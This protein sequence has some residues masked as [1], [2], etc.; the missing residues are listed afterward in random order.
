H[1]SFQGKGG[2]RLSLFGYDPEKDYLAL[3][4]DTLARRINPVDPDRSLLLLK[5]T[6]QIQHE[7]GVRFAKG[8]WPYQLLRQWVA[9]GAP[10]ENGSGEVATL[11]VTPAEYSFDRAG[12]IGQLRVRAK[13][14]DGTEEDI[15][16][17]CDFRTNDETVAEVSPLGQ[18]KAL[19]AGDTA[20]VVTYRGTVVPVR[21]LVPTTLARGFSYPKVPEVN[22]IDR[23]GFAKLRRLRIIPSDRAGDAELLR[24]VTIDTI[25]SLPSPEDV[26][27]FLADTDPNKRAKKIDALLAHP[28]HA[29][30]WATKFSDITGNNTDS[31]EQPPQ[32][33]FK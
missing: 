21:V 6:G 25:G 7:G 26:R 29:A 13:F 32:L 33:K 19:R 23:E 16:P 11:T 20:V 15:T 5:A 30:L 4:R 9:R 22:Y 12:Q 14:R 17:F 1:G 18:V 27:Q 3:S 24:R 2:F 31:L 8:S 28:M 10:W